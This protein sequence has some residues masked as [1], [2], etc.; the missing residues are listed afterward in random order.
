MRVYNY[1]MALA[2]SCFAFSG[3]HSLK[4][5]LILFDDAQIFRPINSEAAVHREIAARYGK[6]L[7][8]AEWRGLCF[9]DDRGLE[10]R[11]YYKD[12]KGNILKSF[13]SKEPTGSDPE[14]VTVEYHT[15]AANE[16]KRYQINYVVKKIRYPGFDEDGAHFDNENV[17]VNFREIR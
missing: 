6:A 4:N 9:L 14:D 13:W 16:G 17:I 8:E 2:F 5:E 12:S 3:C 10:I 7:S 11:F 1:V 15:I